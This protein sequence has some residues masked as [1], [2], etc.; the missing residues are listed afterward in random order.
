MCSA[1]VLLCLIGAARGESVQMKKG[2]GQKVKRVTVALPLKLYGDFL[3]FASLRLWSDSR[4][5]AWL[6]GQGLMAESKK[7]VNRG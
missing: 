6:I 7:K 1:D 5:G 4:A 3:Q 2:S